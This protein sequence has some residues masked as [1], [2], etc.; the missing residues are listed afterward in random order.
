MLWLDIRRLTAIAPSSN[1]LAGEARRS[2][3]ALAISVAL[4]MSILAAPSV[5]AQ[6]ETVLS[7][8]SSATSG[9]SPDGSLLRDVS[10]NL[11][12][13]GDLGCLSEGCFLRLWKHALIGNEM[14]ARAH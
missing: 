9:L 1:R 12:E 7:S 6:T 8:F 4:F 13:I 14:P 11:L 3:A 2:A 5:E 10:G